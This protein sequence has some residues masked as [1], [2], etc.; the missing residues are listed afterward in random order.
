MTQAPLGR[1]W[2]EKSDHGC[3]RE[4]GRKKPE[5]VRTRQIFKCTLQARSGV[6]P[7]GEVMWRTVSGF[8]EE[9]GKKH[10]CV[11]KNPRGTKICWCKRKRGGLQR[12]ISKAG[13][14]LYAQAARDAATRGHPHKLKGRWRL[15]AQVR[16][17][18][19]RVHAEVQRRGLA[20][21]V[22]YTSPTEC[23]SPGGRE[24]AH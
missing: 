17:E 10:P 1:R 9:R 5:A 19:Y 23:H 22:S 24:D 20:E 11:K 3:S 8:G 14:K 4:N 16:P 12:I 6:L 15:W 18:V 2:S 13:W 21:A 7:E